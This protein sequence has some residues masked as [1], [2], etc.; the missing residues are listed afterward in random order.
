M[1]NMSLNVF[2][3]TYDFKLLTILFVTISIR[4]LTTLISALGAC[5]ENRFLVLGKLDGC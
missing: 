4:S 1:L 3:L 5:Q 2:L